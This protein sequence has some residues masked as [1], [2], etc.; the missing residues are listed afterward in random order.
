MSDMRETEIQKD[1][2]KVTQDR[3]KRDEGNGEKERK[4]LREE[5]E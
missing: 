2:K 4:R 3:Q 5:T 1:R